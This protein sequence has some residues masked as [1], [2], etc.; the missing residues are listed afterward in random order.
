MHGT[1]IAT[2]LRIAFATAMVAMLDP[3]DVLGQTAPP[4]LERAHRILNV[5]PKHHDATDDDRRDEPRPFKSIS[6]A[7]KAARP[8]DTIRIAPGI[9]R[10][11]VAL[12]HGG[13][14]GAPLTFEAAVTGGVIVSGADILAGWKRQAGAK[15]IYTTMWSRDFIARPSLKGVEARMRGSQTPVAP[16]HCAE[17][18]IHQDRP[19][20][21]VLTLGE[22]APG[23]FFVDWDADT[24]SVWLAEGADPNVSPVEGV[25]RTTLFAAQ[26]EG[27]APHIT[28]KGLGFRHGATWAQQALVIC[29]ANWQLEDCVFEWANG[30]GLTVRDGARIIRCI[31]QD[32]GQMGFGG[33]GVD[34]LVKDCTLR[35]NNWKGY[36]VS[37]EAGGC[38]FVKVD[39]MRLENM[40]SYENTGHGIWFDIDNRNFVITGCTA[41]NNRGL[42]RDTQ[43]SGI[44]VEISP[45]PGLVEKNTCYGNTGAGLKLAES[46]HLTIRDNLL[47]G[48]GAGVEFRNMAARGYSFGH[49]AVRNNRIKGSRIAAIRTE[50]LNWEPAHIAAH[51]LVIDENTYDTSGGPLALWGKLRF[52]GLEDLRHGL[53]VEREGRIA[54][55][56]FDRPWRPLESQRAAAG[57]TIERAL[58]GKNPG[59][60]V[61]LP[62]FGRTPTGERDAG[63]VTAYDLTAR[64]VTLRVTDPVLRTALLRRVAS[65]PGGTATWVKARLLRS[66][67]TAIE[68]EVLGIPGP[69]R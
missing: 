33:G 17:M 10:E 26:K 58:A 8:G 69:T 11:A 47:V 9:Y 6:A 63:P 55:V 15:P 48:N 41:Y 32:N 27:G 53:G 7:A 62:I 43:G 18:F 46:T 42:D 12:E 39:G 25:T 21:Q 44:F 3:R 36:Q 67:E 40:T 16:V 68:A 34:I 61:V 2:F 13:E 57:E 52:D 5:D 30:R 1:T 56:A 64:Q 14:P 22:L 49:I 29:S 19:L 28:V 37:W 24:V 54:T 60:V 65:Y 51:D 31:G 50:G 59:D 38:K 45:G 66:D 20:W 23:K 35:R 4:P